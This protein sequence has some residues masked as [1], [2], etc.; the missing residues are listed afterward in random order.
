MSVGVF[1]PE[2]IITVYDAFWNPIGEPGQDVIEHSGIDPRNDLP[3]ATLKIKGTS[4]LI[5][6]FQNCRSTM[7]GVTFQTG[8][9]RFAFY[10]DTFDWESDQTSAPTGTAHLLG[11][12]DVLNYLVVWAD[13]FLPIQTQ[14][15]SYAVYIWALCTVIENMIAEQ[16][17]RMQIA[18]YLVI[19]NAFSLNPGILRWF[20]E[21]IR[22]KNTQYEMLRTPVYVVRTNPFLD[23]SPLYARTVRFE[24]CGAVIKDITRAYG[25]DVRVDLW[26][27]GD[28]QPEPWSN[29]T[30]PTYVVTVKDRSQIVGPTKTV[31]D[32][33]LRTVIDVEGPLLGDVLSPLLNPQGL[34]APEGVYI[35]PRLGLYFEKP[36]V[37]VV[38]PEPGMKG[39]VQ[40]VKISDHTPK[41]WQ[42]IIGGRSP[43]WLNDLINS[44]LSWLIDAITIVL[45]FF[46]IPSDLLSGFLNNAFLAFQLVTSFQRRDKVGPY[47]PAIEV[48]HASATSP[49][50]IETLFAFVNALWD[51]RGWSSAQVTF[52]NGEIYTYGEDILRGSLVSVVYAN[53][54]KMLTDYVEN[55]TWRVDAHS[56]DLF[57][58]VGD[59]KAK[60]SPLAKS[61]RLITGAFEA[62]NVLTLSPQSE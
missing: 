25:V 19:N 42:H 45:G 27:P 5:P 13:W 58:Q 10:V 23:T 57:I 54:K 39:S 17:W 4:P 48:F 43:K 15:F 47:H 9:E 34:Y 53:R 26:L 60:E 50:N 24:T 55:V 1:D 38:A 18:L 12:W 59:G 29:L 22:H 37:V 8:S 7:V 6:V 28:P 40:T 35:A 52:R 30:I 14:V 16:A 20:N 36:W 62:I 61:Q 11:I 31:L 21:I 56:R 2:W 51:S 32:S 46:G 33:V 44:S 49:Y 41:G 3:S